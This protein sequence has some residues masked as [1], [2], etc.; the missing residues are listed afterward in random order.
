[1]AFNPIDFFSREETIP[2]ETASQKL[3]KYHNTNYL[4][5]L[6]R[7]GG[8]KKVDLSDSEQSDII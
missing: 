6:E 7:D 2:L 3:L 1:M 4:V 5:N 8:Q